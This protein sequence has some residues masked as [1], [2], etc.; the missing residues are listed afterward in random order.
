M[1]EYCDCAPHLNFAAQEVY[2]S[3]GG[4]QINPMA[5]GIDNDFYE[6]LLTPTSVSTSLHFMSTADVTLESQCGP[7]TLSMTP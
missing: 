7:Y 2:K 5:D 1:L 3:E 4:L 6:L